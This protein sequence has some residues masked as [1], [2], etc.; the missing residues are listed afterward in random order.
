MNLQMKVTGTELRKAGVPMT[1]MRQGLYG[2]MSE[3]KYYDPIKLKKADGTGETTLNEIHTGYFQDEEF[4]DTVFMYLDLYD[5]YKLTDTVKIVYD[6]H[7]KVITLA[8]A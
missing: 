6:E 7:T 1:A 3:R 2:I 4:L 8:K 5:G